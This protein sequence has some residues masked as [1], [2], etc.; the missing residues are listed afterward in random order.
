[1]EMQLCQAAFSG[2]A[3]LIATFSSYLH[4]FISFRVAQVSLVSGHDSTV[5]FIICGYSHEHTS[6]DAI[7]DLY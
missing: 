6:G 3:S 5:W 4:V 1:M 7:Y 2:N